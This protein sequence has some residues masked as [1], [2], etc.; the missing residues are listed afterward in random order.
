MWQ[1]KDNKLTNTLEFKGFSEA[2]NFITLI[3]KEADK[4]NHHPDVFLHE[5]NK[6]EISLTTHDEGKVTEKDHQLAKKIDQ[7]Y[8]K[9]G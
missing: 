8:N 3:A 7:L 6:L 1:E 5:Y 4:M 2:A 9:Q